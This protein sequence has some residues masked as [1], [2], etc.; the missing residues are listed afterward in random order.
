MNLCFTRGFLDNI[1]IMNSTRAFC[2][3]NGRAVSA[4][5][6]TKVLC[7]KYYKLFKVNLEFRF[8][9]SGF[10]F[11]G[12]DIKIHRK[13]NHVFVLLMKIWNKIPKKLDTSGKMQKI[14][15]LPWCPN[16]P[17]NKKD[18]RFIWVS[19]SLGI[20]NFELHQKNE[21]CAYGM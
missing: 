1:L 10:L 8:S 18:L 4:E 12:A 13:F 6:C 17:K 5:I 11:S 19:I 21:K 20:H 14:S 15:V 9:F 7:P 16:L 3:K 2:K